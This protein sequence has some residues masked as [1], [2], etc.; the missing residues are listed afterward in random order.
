MKIKHLKDKQVD[1]KNLKPKMKA[2]KSLVEKYKAAGGGH[3]VPVDAERGLIANLN[4]DETMD[5]F[6]DTRSVAAH[7]ENSYQFQ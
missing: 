1:F 2:R 3:A 5:Q 4:G 7:D 6:P